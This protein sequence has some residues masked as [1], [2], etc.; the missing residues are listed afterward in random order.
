MW[1]MVDRQFRAIIVTH[2][3]LRTGAIIMILGEGKKLP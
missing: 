3:M 2:V 1:T